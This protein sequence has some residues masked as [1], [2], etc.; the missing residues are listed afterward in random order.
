MNRTLRQ[1]TIKAFQYADFQ[2][3]KAYALAFVSLQGFGQIPHVSQ[4]EN[5]IRS[6]LSG[7]DHDS[8]NLQIKPASPHPG[9][10]HLIK[11]GQPTKAG[12]HTIASGS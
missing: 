5:P 12:R 2:S 11:G 4:M 7:L 6:R 9:T 1:A 8:R 10:I 3:I